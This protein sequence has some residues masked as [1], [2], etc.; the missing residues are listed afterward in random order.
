M[1]SE[2]VARF[3]RTTEALTPRRKVYKHPVDDTDFI[4]TLIK[5]AIASG[6]NRTMDI[7]NHVKI[8]RG[9]APSGLAEILNANMDELWAFTKGGKKT[10]HYYLIGS[11]AL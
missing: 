10:K 3:L 8:V 2:E 6:N 5:E 9:I 4:I 11:E 1:T 7:F